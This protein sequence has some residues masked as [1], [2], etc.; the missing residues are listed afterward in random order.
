MATV[1]LI[2]EAGFGNKTLEKQLELETTTI[3][4][5]ELI[6]IRVFNEVADYNTKQPNAFQGLVQPSDTEQVLNGFK[7]KKPRLLDWEA[8]FRKATELFEERGFIVLADD[9][10]IDELDA[11]LDLANINELTF[12]KLVPLVGG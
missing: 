10:Q 2:D 5:R 3:S 9:E 1:T 6:R 7:L 12:L 11:M 4:V 8:Q